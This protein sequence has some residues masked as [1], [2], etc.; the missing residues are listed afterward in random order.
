MEEQWIVDRAH[1][2]SLLQQK[3]YWKNAEY[4]AQCGRSVGWV[5]KWKPILSRAAPDD[6]SVLHSRSRARLRPPPKI[7][8]PVVTAI[9]AIRDEPPGNLRRI[10][11]P[12]TIIYYLHQDEA[13][14]QA[15]YRLPTSTS[16]VWRILDQHHRI[17]RPP[18]IEHEP[19]ERAAPMEEW[20]I[21]FKDVTTVI[22]DGS[23]KRAHQIKAFDVVDA[24]TS[25]LIDN[26]ARTD[27]NATT[28]IETLVD[29]FREQ[30][31]PTYLRFDRDPRFV[32]S[33]S[34]RDFPAAFVRFLHCLGIQ[35][36]ICPPQR[37]DK[38]PFVERYHRSYEY[39]C[40]RPMQPT[41][42]EEVSAVN[43]LFRQHYNFE[44][45]H[46]GLSCGNQPP[47]VAFPRLPILPPLP[48]I[49]DPDKWIDA[50][51]GRYYRRRIQANGSIQ[52]G[53][54]R[55]YVASKE[56]GKSVVVTV[57]AHSRLLLVIQGRTV[58]KSI[59]LKGVHDEL[60][61]LEYYVHM[62][63]REAE[64]EYRQYLSSKFRY[65]SMASTM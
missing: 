6:D 44:R 11:G 55:Y 56:K 12:L 37:P 64:S 9:L 54:Q 13:L 31:M 3:P 41:N 7:S 51:S 29:I 25:I 10:P 4:A 61:S 2:R 1:L 57:D 17:L 26:P 60:M 53:R 46:Q 45:P 8:E 63:S 65:Q 14:R 5:K 52:V 28:V 47:R 30:G 33:W 40:L 43:A 58:I 16:T 23:E 48:P 18:P 15:G 24:G 50:I 59:P 42:L 35:P 32:G 20:Q 19:L 62:I 36:I 34:G 39:E 22:D 49:I 27:F 21:D 38:N